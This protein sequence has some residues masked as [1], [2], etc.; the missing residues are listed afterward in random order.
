MS[1][2]LHLKDCIEDGAQDTALGNRGP[3][4]ELIRIPGEP[5]PQVWLPDKVVGGREYPLEK[6]A[7]VSDSIEGLGHVEKGTLAVPSCLKRGGNKVHNAKALIDCGMERPE[8]ETVVWDG[9]FFI[10]DVK[11]ALKEE[12]FKHLRKKR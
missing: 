8:T 5:V 1:E 11:D 2:T 6:K 10:K 9:V 7:R 3:D 12:F 4:R